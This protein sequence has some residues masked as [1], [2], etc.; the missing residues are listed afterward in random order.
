MITIKLKN[1]QEKILLQLMNFDLKQ[2]KIKQKLLNLAYKMYINYQM[3]SKK[4]N[5]LEKKK[6]KKN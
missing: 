1:N 6:K 2:K 5:Q 3:S 4:K